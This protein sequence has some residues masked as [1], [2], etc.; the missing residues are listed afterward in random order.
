MPVCLPDVL[1]NAAATLERSAPVLPRLREA[2]YPAA[3][4]GQDGLENLVVPWDEFDV[5]FL[6]GSTTWKL[7]RQ[8]WSLSREAIKRGKRVHMGR[9]NSY[10]R[11]LYA[12]EIGCDSADG[13]FLAFAPTRRLLR[14]LDR[15]QAYN[16]TPNF[17]LV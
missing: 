12:Q 5:L 10:K 1:R 8:A 13:T 7:S 6:G 17:G 2:G 14:I 3:L 16:E 11:L 9:V 4:V 15:V